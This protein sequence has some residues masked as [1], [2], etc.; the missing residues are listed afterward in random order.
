MAFLQGALHGSRN[1]LARRLENMYRDQRDA[2][3]DDRWERTH[4]LKRATTQSHLQTA[5]QARTFA[6]ALQP[7]QLTAAAL[8]KYSTR[9]GTV[10]TGHRTPNSH[11]NNRK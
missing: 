5:E 9:F 11:R 10:S 7:H 1:L 6:A 4:A 2:I 3:A 8:A